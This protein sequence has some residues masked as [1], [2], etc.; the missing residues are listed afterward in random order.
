MI[1]IDQ[2]RF[3]NLFTSY[4]IFMIHEM[5]K[6]SNPWKSAQRGA[7]NMYRSVKFNYAPASSET[8]INKCFSGWRI[9][10][11]SFCSQSELPV[12]ATIQIMLTTQRSNSWWVIPQH[13][14]L[15]YADQ[16]LVAQK[17]KYFSFF[18]FNLNIEQHLIV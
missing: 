1:L 2:F 14:S 11:A 15:S 3:E 6:F 18:L 8:R 10:S 13:A 5:I 12:S 4:Q 9:Y 7:M 17:L 16:L